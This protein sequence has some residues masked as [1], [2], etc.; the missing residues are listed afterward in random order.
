M[1][2]Y[3]EDCKLNRSGECIPHGGFD[4]KPLSEKPTTVLQMGLDA[5]GWQGGTIHQVADMLDLPLRVLFHEKGD[6][7]TFIFK[8]GFLAD[9][10]IEAEF[11]EYT[12]IAHDK[13]GKPWLAARI[14]LPG[15]N[16]GGTIEV[17]VDRRLQRW[18]KP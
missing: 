2:I 18:I 17:L 1:T 11:I 12:K 7:V 3:G 15:F 6:K 5:F 9:Q 13:E 4:H 8:Q 14:F 16:S 10:P